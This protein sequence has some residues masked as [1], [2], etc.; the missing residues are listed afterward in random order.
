MSES[1][2]AKE[3]LNQLN[4]KGYI[5]DRSKKSYE[6]RSKKIEEEL[7][8]LEERSNEKERKNNESFINLPSGL[9]FM[10]DNFKITT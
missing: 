4:K 9:I 10:V 6:K 8:K 7:I 2:K 3:I 1:E 5:K